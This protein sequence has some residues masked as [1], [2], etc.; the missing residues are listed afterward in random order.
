MSE[1]TPRKLNAL[2]LLGV[3][4]LFL[5]SIEP[6]NKIF[7]GAHPL[8]LAGVNFLSIPGLVCFALGVYRFSTTGKQR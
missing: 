4:I 6:L 7:A 1:M 3:G 8:I 2:V 5:V